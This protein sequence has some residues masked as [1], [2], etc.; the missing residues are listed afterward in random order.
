MSKLNQNI[1]GGVL[2]WVI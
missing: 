2:S 1:N